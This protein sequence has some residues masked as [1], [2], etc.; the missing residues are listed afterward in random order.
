[1]NTL[2]NKIFYVGYLVR[3]SLNFGEACAE[4]YLW[5]VP[6]VCELVK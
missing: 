3:I 4:V 6:D 1:M 2:V 5:D